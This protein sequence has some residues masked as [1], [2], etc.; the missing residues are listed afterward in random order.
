[1]GLPWQEGKMHPSAPNAHA[2]T[3]QS[4]V[5]LKAGCFRTQPL[6]NSMYSPHHAFRGFARTLSLLN[7]KVWGQ[8]HL[9]YLHVSVVSTPRALTMNAGCHCVCQLNLVLITSEWGQWASSPSKLES[10]AMIIITTNKTEC[11]LCARHRE[12]Y[13]NVQNRSALKKL[14]SRRESTRRD[15]SSLE[16]DIKAHEENSQVS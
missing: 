9:T 3:R 10:P 7:Q 4:N 13:T 14:L 1:M 5:E 6:I 2:H 8:G 11:L 16:Q 12:G 15:S